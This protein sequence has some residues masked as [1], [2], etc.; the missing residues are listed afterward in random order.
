MIND[1]QNI[2]DDPNSFISN[3]TFYVWEICTY[4]ITLYK[5]KCLYTFFHLLILSSLLLFLLN[6]IIHMFINGNTIL[7]LLIVRVFIFYV[8]LLYCSFI[9]LYAL[10][11]YYCHYYNIVSNIITGNNLFST[12]WSLSS[13][14]TECSLFWFLDLSIPFLTLWYK[15]GSIPEFWLKFHINAM[16]IEADFEIV[17]IAELRWKSSNVYLAKSES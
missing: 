13:T 10:Y 8:Y 3:Y 5:W 2:E 9:V 15:D 17:S 4:F 14:T 6:I 11:H 1:T 16:I 12:S 7:V